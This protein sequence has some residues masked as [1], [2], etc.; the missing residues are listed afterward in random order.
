MST[1]IAYLKKRLLDLGRYDLVSAAERGEVSF[2]ACAEEAGLVRRREVQGNGSTNQAK[3]RAWAL[4]RITR[5]AASL[6]PQPQP[7]TCAEVKPAPAEKVVKAKPKKR[8]SAKLDPKKLDVR[9]L[10]G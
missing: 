5:Q 1:S 9:A 6:A 7:E 10:V 2:Y 4:H 3:T 8:V